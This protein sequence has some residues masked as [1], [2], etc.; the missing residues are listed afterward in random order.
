MTL[1]EQSVN[2]VRR[3]FQTV[4][5]EDTR[6][7]GQAHGSESVILRDDNVPGT[8]AVDKGKIHAVRALVED[9]G[10]GSVPLNAVGGIAQ[11]Q[12]RNAVSAA[13]ADG[14]V[15]DRAAVGVDQNGWHGR[16]SFI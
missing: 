2:V 15:D 3:V 7:A 9:H 16:T 5:I 10:L 8:H 6:T 13:D 14:Q 1:F 12:N 4:L 11:N